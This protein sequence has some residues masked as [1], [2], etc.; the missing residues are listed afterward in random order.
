MELAP[1]DGDG[2]VTAGLAGKG[3]HDAPEISVYQ[4]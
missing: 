1:H 2:P 3:L 4:V